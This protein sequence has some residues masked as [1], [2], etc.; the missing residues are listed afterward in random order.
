MSK[1]QGASGIPASS[2]EK[3]NSLYRGLFEDLS[4]TLLGISPGRRSFIATLKRKTYRECT[5]EEQYAIL[6]IL[7]SGLQTPELSEARERAL[8]QVCL[9]DDEFYGLSKILE[10]ELS[11]RKKGKNE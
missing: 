6:R 3:A 8:D 10:K 2:L 5:G 1:E 7:F 4:G 11:R 9:G